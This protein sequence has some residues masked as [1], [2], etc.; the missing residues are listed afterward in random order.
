MRAK[1]EKG[2]SGSWSRGYK[3]QFGGMSDRSGGPTKGNFTRWFPMAL[4]ATWAIN[5]APIPPLLVPKHHKFYTSLSYSTTTDLCQS[6]EIRAP[7]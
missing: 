3:T 6:R 5:R 1:G 4:L 2:Q 7:F